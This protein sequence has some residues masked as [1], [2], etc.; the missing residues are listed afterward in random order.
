MDKIGYMREHGIEEVMK[1]FKASD[2][3][4]ISDFIDN[5]LGNIPT[6]IP[7]PYDEKTRK[8]RDKTLPII[9][10]KNIK[11]LKDI[12][13]GKIKTKDTAIINKN[14]FLAEISD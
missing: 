14:Q 5:E 7:S 13:E 10:E 11:V 4:C 9:H 2:F 6:E 12:K 3:T 1:R 8:K